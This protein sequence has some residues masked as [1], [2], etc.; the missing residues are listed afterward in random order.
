MNSLQWKA[1]F[2]SDTFAAQGLPFDRPLNNNQQS[3]YN[4][5]KRAANFPVQTRALMLASL[6]HLLNSYKQTDSTSLHISISNKSGKLIPAIIQLSGCSNLAHLQ[7]ATDSALEITDRAD[8][9]TD[10]KLVSLFDT[11]LNNLSLPPN[12]CCFSLS[13]DLKQVS[14]SGYLHFI[15]FNEGDSQQ[16]GIKYDANL[17]D[18]PTVQRMLD[19]WVYVSNK[20]RVRSGDI[21]LSDIPC[22]SSNNR[23]TLLNQW[24]NTQSLLPNFESTHQ[25]F[26]GHVDTHPNRICACD[27]NQSY[28]YIQLE[29]ESNHIAWALI[30]YGVKS[31]DLIALAL[32]RNVQLISTILAVFK[33][34]A[35]YVPLDPDFPDD[36]LAYMASHSNSKILITTEKL[37]DRFSFFSGSIITIESIL[38]TKKKLFH[39]PNLL[40]NAHDTAY[41]I[42]TSGSTGKPKGVEVLQSGVVNLLLSMQKSPG[43]HREDV[44][45][46]IT[47]LSFDI[48]V[49]EILL[50]LYSGASV[51]MV[52]KEISLFA[53]KL[54]TLLE[55]FS[56]TFLQATPATFRLLVSQ[57]WSPSTKIKVLC[58]GEPFPVDLA[59]D[60]IKKADSVWNVYGPTETSV[61]STVH[62]VKSIEPPILIGRPIDNTSI[63]ILDNNL[64]LT[65]IGMPGNL[66]IGGAGLAKG[67]LHQLDLTNERFIINPFDQTNII[68]DTG[69][70][71][72]YTTN[73]EIECLGRSDGQ[74]KIRGYRIELGEVESCLSNCIGIQSQVVIAREDEPGNQQLVAYYLT[75]DQKPLKELDLKIQ[76]SN[77]LPKYMTPNRVIHL[78]EFPM[79]LNFK[80]DR[81]SLPK[82][83]Q[84]D[85]GPTDNKPVTETEN[86]IYKIWS[87]TLGL[88]VIDTHDNFFDI[89]GNSLLSIR[90]FTAIKKQS[91]INLPLDTL[92]SYFSIKKLASH[93][94]DLKRSGSLG[95]IDNIVSKNLVTIKKAGT[96]L[97][98]FFF[99]GVGGNVLN[100]IRLVNSIDIE[101]P[102]YGLQ[103]SGVDGVS[104]LE[105]SYEDMLNSYLKEI[106]A[107][108]GYGPYTLVG[109][110]MGGVTAL[111]IANKLSA[112]GHTIER[113]IMFD[114]FG[115]HLVVPDNE[116]AKGVRDSLFTRIK[117]FSQYKLKMLASKALPP[118]YSALNIRLPY[119]VRYQWIE[120]NNY[121]LMA[122]RTAIEYSGAVTLIRAP[123]HNSGPYSDP[124][125][126]WSKTLIGKIDIRYVE[127]DHH[128]I[129][130]SKTSSAIFNE[131]LSSGT[132]SREMS[133]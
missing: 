54:I 13:K 129:V 118:V 87:D 3:N 30:N 39:R 12:Q 131:L 19:N 21:L 91:S 47:T 24:S 48:S 20:F 64:Q 22:I 80:I 97:P 121:K 40:S 119:T 93:I 77:L 113:V 105:S 49:V 115:P 100:Y 72:K 38:A 71:A 27:I 5:I 114:S 50:P 128:N 75:K 69:D 83:S 8:S 43:A 98:V 82:P 32:P 52:E 123:M 17:F 92:F 34:T 130:E 127:G 57:D 14:D 90:I 106:L 70:I 111:D 96:G 37:K 102:S 108:Q 120:N 68:Y 74:V 29:H 31:G 62:Q 99:H 2:T 60:L 25:A 122:M 126:G 61:W 7:Q 124:Y 10:E 109:G 84:L 116:A 6:S 110:S 51:V 46:A 28:S 85:N 56:V 107:I 125:L 76:L 44:F 9:L 63:Y 78:A 41:V 104:R 15:I 81:N 132:H 33:S 11:E 66:Y 73:G 55:K 59:K 112:L 58:G 65:Q 26:E 101:R 1:A 4:I 67:Y 23:D 42:Y 94:D 79:T 45:C 36:R 133:A 86:L 35:A 95:S 103:S 16:I 88:K 53:D 117:G 89:G 18:E